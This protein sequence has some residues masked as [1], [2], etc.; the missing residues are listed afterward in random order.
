MFVLASDS[1]GVRFL[2]QRGAPPLSTSVAS[3]RRRLSARLFAQTRILARRIDLSSSSSST[4]RASFRS[5][6]KSICVLDVSSIMLAVS[7]PAFLAL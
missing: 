5:T 1:V 7:N 6:G 4:S 3:M 2:I